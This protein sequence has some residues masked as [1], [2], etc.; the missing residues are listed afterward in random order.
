MTPTATETQGGSTNDSTDKWNLRLYI[1]GDSPN[2]RAALANLEQ[3]CEQY[4]P[5]RYEIEVVDL[6]KDPVLARD[7]QI[8]AIPTLV[9][10]LPEPMRRIIGDLSNAD[11]ALVALDLSCSTPGKP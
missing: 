6:I 4:L 11:K 5:G 1:A 10:K 3:L 9:R 8:V 2:S 7:H